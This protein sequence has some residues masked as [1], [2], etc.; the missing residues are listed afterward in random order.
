VNF[1]LPTA[2]SGGNPATAI[3]RTARPLACP[4]WP[5]GVT[6]S[7]TGRKRG[8]ARAG[9]LAPALLAVLAAFL[10]SCG[11]QAPPQ[12]PRVE[13][14]ETIKDL[15]VVQTG[16]TLNTTFTMPV[17][18]TDGEQLNKPV[19]VGIF[20][21]ISPT[22]QQPGQ[23]DTSGAPWL[24]L[25]PKELPAYTRAGKVDYPIVFSPQEFRQGQG[26]TFSFAVI[27]FTRGFRGHPRKSAP[28]NVVRVALLD[29]TR[30]VTNLEAKASQTALLLTWDKPSETLTGL[31]PSHL[32]GYRVYQ[33][34]T[35]KPDSFRLLGE[36]ASNQFEDTNFQF[37]QQYYFRVSGVTTINGAAAESEPSETVGI[38]PRDVFPPPVPTG[39]SAVNAAGA[40]DLLWNASSAGDLAGYNVYRSADGGP[41]ER[42]NKQR[43]P[44]PIFHDASVA[45]AR[46]YQYAVTAVD[47]TGNESGKSQPANITTPSTGTQ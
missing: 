34:A 3:I 5:L 25:S 13:I 17:L 22:G 12:P 21:A 37:G 39:L 26:S 23:P 42:V 1:Q 43:V 30:P 6:R 47:L 7:P 15:R 38:T 14:P 10:A 40:V 28:S 31:P 19:T 24:S 9:W 33:S 11:V 16:R 32:F 46:K 45:S 35:G 20:R 18:A 2:D 29:V 4:R 41:F 27:A 8:P 36:A 44:T